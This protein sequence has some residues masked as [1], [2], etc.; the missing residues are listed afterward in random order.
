[1]PVFIP[2]IVEHF[3]RVCSNLFDIS[4]VHKCMHL[5]DYNENNVKD[6]LNVNTSTA[7]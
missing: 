1:M 6:T 5:P 7:L 4:A 2:N 3:L